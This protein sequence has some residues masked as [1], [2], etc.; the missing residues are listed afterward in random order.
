M[1]S[2]KFAYV[3]LRENVNV[4]FLPL[5]QCYTLVDINGV[6]QKFCTEPYEC[7]ILQRN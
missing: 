6:L 3:Q 5:R 4:K 2:L 1:N 7:R